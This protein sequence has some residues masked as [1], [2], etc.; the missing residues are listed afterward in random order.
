M[1]YSPQNYFPSV[2]LWISTSF[3]DVILFV[4]LPTWSSVR[5][6]E[7]SDCP[8]NDLATNS[9]SLHCRRWIGIFQLGLWDP[10]REGVAEK[11]GSVPVGLG[12]GRK[13]VWQDSYWPCSHHFYLSFTSF[14]S[15]LWSP[16]WQ[17]STVQEKRCSAYIQWKITELLKKNEAVICSN[18]D[19]PRDYHTWVK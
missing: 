15:S 7:P 12:D 11:N 3:H 14:H 8:Y 17:K 5:L 9:H 19:G 16:S 4:L 1:L 10:P 6:T 18:M 13:C 2:I